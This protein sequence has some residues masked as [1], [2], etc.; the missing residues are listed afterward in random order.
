MGIPLYIMYCFFL[1]AFNICSLCLIFISLTNKHLAVFLLE[2][3]LYGVIWASWSWVAISSPMLWKFLTV[4]SSN[5]FSYAFF[6][7]FFFSDPYNLDVGSLSVVL[8]VSETVVISFILF[9]LFY[10]ASVISTIIS[11]SSL[12]C[13]SASVILLLFPSSVFLNFSFSI[14][15]C[16]LSVL[17]FFWVLVKHFLYLLP[18]CLYSIYLCLHITSEIFDHVYYHYSEFIFR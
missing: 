16:S 12:I 3:I 5:I 18:P 10:S 13:S 1:A 17:Y 11:S 15:H 8:E 2:F 4:I 7:L 6:F 9:F 14:V